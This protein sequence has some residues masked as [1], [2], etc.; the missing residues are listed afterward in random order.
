MKSALRNNESGEGEAG[1][2]LTLQPVVPTHPHSC[3][4]P[5]ACGH[6]RLGPNTIAMLLGVI[7]FTS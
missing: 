6:R 3:T 1:K 5:S 2:A 7:L 4:H